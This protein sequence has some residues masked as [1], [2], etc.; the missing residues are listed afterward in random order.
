M[1]RTLRPLKLDE[2]GDQPPAGVVPDSQPIV[3]PGRTLTFNDDGTPTGGNNPEPA[4]AAQPAPSEEIVIGGKKFSNSK[5]AWAYA[6]ELEQEN[7]NL[8]A[9]SQGLREGVGTS[10]HYQQPDPEPEE[11]LSED[12][13]FTDPVGAIKKVASKVEQQVTSRIE[14]GNQ[15][16][17]QVT[18]FWNEFYGSNED[19]QGHKDYCEYTLNNNMNMFADMKDFKLAHGKLATMVRN[20]LN[21]TSS[22]SKELP[23]T[24]HDASPGSSLPGVIPGN[25][26][27]EPDDNDELDFSSQVKQHQSNK[28]KLNYGE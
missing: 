22:N 17:N 13:Y 1:L 3:Q 27:P 18:Q 25:N 5:E 21:L 15:R 20:N 14:S 11:L 26:N 24:P 8:N 16:R 7:A 9:Y 4:P 10:Q 12:D 23:N 19:L 6:Q 2:A 28:R